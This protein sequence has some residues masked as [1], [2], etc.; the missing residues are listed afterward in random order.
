M[1]DR[2]FFCSDGAAVV[3]RFLIVCLIWVYVEFS[4]FGIV[5]FGSTMFSGRVDLLLRLDSSDSRILS[6]KCFC[7]LLCCPVIV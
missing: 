2:L 3:I 4:R 7:I 1:S 5:A 6:M